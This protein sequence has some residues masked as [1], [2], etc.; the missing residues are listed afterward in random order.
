MQIPGPQVEADIV[1]R[2]NVWIGYS[3]IDHRDFPQWVDVEKNGYIICMCICSTMAI[4]SQVEI[5]A[6]T[7]ASMWKQTL[8]GFQLGSG[9][10][11]TGGAVQNF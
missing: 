4:K 5:K 6:N 9:L 8:N 7:T 10:D 2:T 3:N 1:G 11:W